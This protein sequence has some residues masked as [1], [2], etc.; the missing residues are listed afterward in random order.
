MESLKESLAGGF[1]DPLNGLLERLERFLQVSPLGRQES[2]PLLQLP[3]LFN[4]RQVYLSQLVNEALKFGLADP[5]LG[6]AVASP[7][8][9]GA[10]WYP[11]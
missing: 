1:V 6:F 3:V 4:R 8:D 7:P 5:M 9:S 10:V 2:K 11:S